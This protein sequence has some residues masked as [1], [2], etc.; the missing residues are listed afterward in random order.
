MAEI[1]GSLPPSLLYRHL[2]RLSPYP[3]VS[4]GGRRSLPCLQLSSCL[5]P[6]KSAHTRTQTH[7]DTLA[8]QASKLFLRL[9]CRNKRMCFDLWKRHRG[10]LQRLHTGCTRF[11][12][13]F[14]RSHL[15]RCLKG[16]REQVSE[17]YHAH[18]VKIRLVRRL[19]RRLVERVLGKWLLYL[20]LTTDSN[21][22]KLLQSSI[23]PLGGR[24]ALA[25]A[26]TITWRR[27]ARRS[28][29]S[30]CKAVEIARKFRKAVLAAMFSQR[31]LL[32]IRAWRL[33]AQLKAYG[34]VRG[35]RLA[36]RAW[37]W[38]VGYKEH[39]KCVVH[40]GDKVA[41]RM[42][43]LLMYEVMAEWYALLQLRFRQVVRIG[44]SVSQA[45]LRLPT[46]FLFCKSTAGCG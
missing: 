33:L 26:S 12:H 21:V 38:W 1:S 9:V 6:M 25:K 8:H 20:S 5:R 3:I 40:T 18:S 13:S 39:T 42:E 45:H 16:W 22:V 15:T 29:R 34:R 23:C 46:G 11:L 37:Q 24:L 28:G 10:S 4:A 44:A 14:L 27:L 36:L 7:V 43:Q 35:C 17:R 32:L 30:A 19:R 41:R 2:L 31:L